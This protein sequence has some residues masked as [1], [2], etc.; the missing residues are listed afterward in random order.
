MV[1]CT[2]TVGARVHLADLRSVGD[3]RELISYSADCTIIGIQDELAGIDGIHVL[4]VGQPG[5]DVHSIGIDGVG[6]VFAIGGLTIVRCLPTSTPA[7]GSG[8]YHHPE[9]RRNPR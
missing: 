1:L 6:Q 9:Q 4:A 5:R 7:A 3:Q 8:L 2:G